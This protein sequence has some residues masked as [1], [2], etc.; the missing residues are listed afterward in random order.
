MTKFRAAIYTRISQNDPKVQKV[1]TQE[2]NL[3]KL[4]AAEGY[5]VV[6]VFTDDGISAFSGKARPAF[7]R[8]K[9]AIKNGK[10]DLI[11]AVA[12]DRL[13][14]NTGDK[15]AL[16]V[17]CAKAG[18]TWHTIAGGLVDPSTAGGGLLSN[19]TGAI[20]EYESAVKV[21][22][23]NAALA[24]RLAD[25]KPLWGVRPFGFELVKGATRNSDT[26]GVN[27]AE[28]EHVREAC[29]AIISGATLY[30]VQKAFN[31]SGVLTSR[32]NKWSYQTVR[33][34]V[35]R[36]RNAGLL[37]SHGKEYDANLPAIITVDELDAVRAILSN[38]ARE[39]V[40]G[41]KVTKHFATG[42]VMCG[43]CGAPMKSASARSRGRVLPI[44]KCSKKMAVQGFG[45]THPTIQRD[46]L[47]TAIGWNVYADLATYLEQMDADNATEDKVALLAPL[48]A[49]RAEIERQRG[50]A[51]EIAMMP[52]ANLVTLRKTLTEL[53]AKA[54]AVEGKIADATR[55][56]AQAAVL[57]NVQGLVELVRLEGFS[58]TTNLSP[59]NGKFLDQW[60]ALDI[61]DKRE[62]IKATL[63]IVVNPTKSDKPRIE[64]HSIR[65]EAA[66]ARIQREIQDTPAGRQF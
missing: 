13:A 65:G 2:R 49:E 55:S 57:E 34:M 35:L 60:E 10:F 3:R 22:R 37:V 7:I 27:E 64:F 40:P 31:D 53:E 19:I 18:V 46:I 51:Q 12:E 58:K 21:E 44:Y 39:V 6:E 8:L 32:G 56:S 25:G 17:D 24:A 59:F 52:G 11:L 38:P 50:V 26:V 62:L 36:P 47:E 41:P 54:E 33:Q 45:E 29:A 61:A 48:R 15:Y 14:R 42:L 16:A 5:T 43:V 63:R 9:A 1:E 28:A 4:A 20:A 30:S 23:V 66:R